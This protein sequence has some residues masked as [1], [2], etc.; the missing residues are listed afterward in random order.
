MYW[1]EFGCVV[2]MLVAVTGCGDRL[3]MGTVTT[4][5]PPSADSSTGTTSGNTN[6]NVG[7]STDTTDLATTE[8][9]EHE[10]EHEEL[11]EAEHEATEADDDLTEDGS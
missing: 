3:V 11:E 6:T 7:P 2:A 9:D 10:H 4:N 8:D 1:T 5:D